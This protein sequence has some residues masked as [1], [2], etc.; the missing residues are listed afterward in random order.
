MS[1]EE[2]GKSC[3]KNLEELLLSSVRDPV[4]DG[5]CWI[6]GEQQNY[7]RHAL[8]VYFYVVFIAVVKGTIPIL[9]SPFCFVASL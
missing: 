7:F 9:P 8:H 2:K 1:P 4:H 3:N 6:F 5:V